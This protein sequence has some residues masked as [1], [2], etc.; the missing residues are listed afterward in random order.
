MGG[1]RSTPRPGRFT[2]GKDQVLTV[3]EAGCAPVLVWTGAENLD[4]TGIRSPDHPARSESLYRLSYPGSPL[5][6]VQLHFL[7]SFNNPTSRHLNGVCGRDDGCKGILSL[8]SRTGDL[9]H[10]RERRETLTGFLVE[11][12]YRKETSGKTKDLLV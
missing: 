7:L 1:G 2:P 9:L 4:P 11:E 12:T 5:N 8:S 6:V 10:V 3:Q